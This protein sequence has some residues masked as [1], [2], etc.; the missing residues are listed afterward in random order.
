MVWLHI[1]S[2]VALLCKTLAYI[3]ALPT[4]S[5]DASIQGGP[6]VTDVSK[7]YLQWYPNGCVGATFSTGAAQKL[8]CSSY[9]QNVSYQLVGNN[10]NGISTVSFTFNTFK[11][12][13]PADL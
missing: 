4:N 8:C 7:I 10:S 6:N 11:L 9:S 13:L 12:L 2:I 1:L 3:P 5:T